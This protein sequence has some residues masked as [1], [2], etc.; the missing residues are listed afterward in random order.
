MTQT[1]SDY[2]PYSNSNRS[3]KEAPK[4]KTP[5]KSQ[6][7]ASSANLIPAY[8]FWVILFLTSIGINVYNVY[9]RFAPQTMERFL[10]S[11]IYDFIFGL[12]VFGFVAFLVWVGALAAVFFTLR[13]MHR[14]KLW[15]N[16]VWWIILFCS[17]FVLVVGLSELLLSIPFLVALSI[18]GLLQYLEI[19]F[20]NAK[21]KTTILWIVVITAYLIEAWMQYDMLPFHHDYTTALGLVKDMMGM[22]FRWEGFKPLQGI[23]ALVGIFGIEAGD[24]MIKLVKKCA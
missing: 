13:T 15:G 9:N 23:L 20:W 8:F 24:R 22:S 6:K 1:T 4:P 16:P 10:A 11:G 21:R 17:A 5:K 14:Y 12:P 3:K 7:S 18:V 19:I 2:S